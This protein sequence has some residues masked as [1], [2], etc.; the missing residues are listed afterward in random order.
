MVSDDAFL[1][2][3]CNEH[4]V[5]YELAKKLKVRIFPLLENAHIRLGYR[6]HKAVVE[7]RRAIDIRLE[8]SESV[9]LVLKKLPP[10]LFSMREGKAISLHLEYLTLVEGFFATQVDFLIF[11]LI[12]NGHDLY[13]FRKG[14][15]V[16]K[17]NDIEEVNLA[18]K[19]KFLKR[20]GFS[21]ITS[22]VNVKLRNSVA[23][24]FYQ[25]DKNGTIRFG[26]QKITEREY[27]RLCNDLRDVTFGILLVNKIYYRRFASAETPA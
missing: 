27:G 24:L 3:L 25:I 8:N 1:T 15:Y 14:K 20:H 5:N 16:E 2:N 7:Q 6:F 10:A 26:K 17:L 11:T 22:K 18:F 21:F 12:A 23:H 9:Q 4:N 19:L 13:S